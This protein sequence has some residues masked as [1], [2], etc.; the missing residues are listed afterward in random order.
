MN[1]RF[2]FWD[3]ET[4]GLN[5]YYDK[6]IEIAAMDNLGNKFHTLINITKPIPTK[7]TEIT[8]ITDKMLIGQPSIDLALK[9]FIEFIDD[10]SWLI[11]HNSI[12]FDQYFLLCAL[13]KAGFKIRK[14]KHLDTLCMAQIKHP[15]ANSYSLKNLCAYFGIEQ[16]NAHRAM[17]DV[18][19]TK[20]LF[21]KLLW[22][23]NLEDIYDKIYI[24]DVCEC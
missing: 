13:K 10:A 6:I 17:N 24:N 21:D 14:H 20:S 16:K 23:S 11:G 5:P 7:V 9:S 8:G 12:K 2:I 3:L 18:I 4:T 22:S 15:R 1:H 19:A